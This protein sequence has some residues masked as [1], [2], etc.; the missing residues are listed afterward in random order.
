MARSNLHANLA[1]SLVFDTLR[2]GALTREEFRVDRS[3]HD[4]T[5]TRQQR[6]QSRR[7]SHSIQIDQVL[8]SPI[9]TERNGIREPMLLAHAVAPAGVLC[10]AD[11]LGEGDVHDVRVEI[12]EGN[13][14]FDPVVASWRIGKDYVLGHVGR[15]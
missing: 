10:A 8:V 4:G 5:L 7:I 11:G 14:S 12:A 2:H 13:R 9:L 3:L 6:K 15:I 1:I